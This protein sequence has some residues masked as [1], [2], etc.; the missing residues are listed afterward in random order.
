MRQRGCDERGTLKWKMIFLKYWEDYS[1]L[2]H[3]ALRNGNEYCN[4]NG[5]LTCAHVMAHLAGM[6]ST[7]TS[8][9]Q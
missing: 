3:I 4:A 2:A 7:A 1:L 8:A 5:N 9:A 6:Q